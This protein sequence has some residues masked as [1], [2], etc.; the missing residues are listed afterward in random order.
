MWLCLIAYD[1]V[2]FMRQSRMIFIYDVVYG[3]IYFTKEK[4]KLLVIL[5]PGKISRGKER[6]LEFF[7]QKLSNFRKLVR[8]ACI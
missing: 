6:A 2:R 8:F 5:E 3:V 7:R 4:E 1:N